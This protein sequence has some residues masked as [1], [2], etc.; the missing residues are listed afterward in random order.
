M[1]TEMKQYLYTGPLSGVT[2]E[3]STKGGAPLE[4]LLHPGHEYSFPPTNK[5]VKRLVARGLLTE[6]QPQVVVE[7][8][9]K[10]KGSDA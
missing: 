9:K 6:V 4:T 7:E 1:R 3:P 5:W 2:L 10:G 8:K